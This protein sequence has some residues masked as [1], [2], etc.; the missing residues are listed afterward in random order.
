MN[1]RNDSD[2][3]RNWK[4]TLPATLAGRVEFLL[5]SPI[6]Q[7]PI[8]GAR[9]RLVESLLEHWVARETGGALPPIPTIEQLR[10]IE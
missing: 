1:K 2:I 6:Y 5:L 3:I 10:S 9:A 4:I 7:K 8:Y